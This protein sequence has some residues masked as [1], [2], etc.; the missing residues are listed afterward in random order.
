MPLKEKRDKILENVDV[1]KFGVSPARMFNKLHDKMGK[2][3]L[4]KI[5]DDM[6]SNAKK[7][8]KCLNV[9]NK[10]I[11]KKIKEKI[12]YYFIN[13]KVNNEIEIFFKFS[14]KIDVFKLKLGE[15]KYTEIS[16]KIQ[17]QIDFEPYSNSIF[18]IFPLTYCTVRHIDNSIAFVTNKKVISVYQFNCM[19]TAVENKN[20]K[21]TEDKLYKEIFIGD[22]KGTL[23]LLEIKY[24]Y[25]HHEKNYEIKSIYQKKSIK[26]FENYIKGLLHIERLNTIFSWSDENERFISINNDYSLEVLNII[27]FENKTDIK[28]ILVSKYDLIFISCCNNY[29][30]YKK[31]KIYC[32]TLNGMMIS[33]YET[34]ENIVK[35]FTEE[36]FNIVLWNNNVLSYPLYSFDEACRLFY[37]DFTKDLKAWTIK[38]NSCQ[39]FPKNKIYLIISSNNKATFLENNKDFI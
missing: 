35:C 19:I 33:F 7:N 18:E 28:E 23:H 8:E 13:T 32:Y 11:T 29:D 39:Y 17:E 26:I 14:N 25:N 1:L 21:N 3:N 36:K 12:L 22:E 10:Y 5:E 37:C 30:I 4:E 2:K 27:K 20:N 16:L 34:H 24:E 6:V 31:N 38:I 15:T 9:I